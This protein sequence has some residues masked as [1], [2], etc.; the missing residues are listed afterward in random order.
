MTA[1]KPINHGASSFQTIRDKKYHIKSWGK[2]DAPLLIYLHGWADTG[3][4]FQ[5]VVDKFQSN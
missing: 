5:F 4:T 2:T 3:S 1:Y